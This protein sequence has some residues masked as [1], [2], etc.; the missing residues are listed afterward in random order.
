MYFTCRKISP[1]FRTFPINY[2]FS[3]NYIWAHLLLRK[4]RFSRHLKIICIT[5]LMQNYRKCWLMC[6]PRK[7]SYFLRYSNYQYTI[8]HIIVIELK[9]G[10]LN[11]IESLV[12]FPGWFSPRPGWHFVS[13]LNLILMNFFS[14][15]EKYVL[16]KSRV[17]INTRSGLYLS[18][19]KW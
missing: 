7:S 17:F 13:M 14:K 16:V 12:P 8:S 2:I 3:K 15:F 5:V 11:L 10:I 1:G 9:F 19:L 18:S 4:T 6:N